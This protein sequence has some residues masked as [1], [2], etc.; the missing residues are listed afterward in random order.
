MSK[1]FI[2]QDNGRLDFTKAQRFGDLKPVAAGE[3]FPDNAED[4]V[5]EVH[6]I[7]EAL[8]RDFDPDQDYV[9]LAGDP[10]IMAIT[11]L[12]LGATFPQD[13]NFLKWDRE[14]REYYPVKL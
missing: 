1:V 10:I 5:V 14:N 4:R 11:C 2:T 3:V 7:V 6:H 13:L 8:F 9:L 12:H